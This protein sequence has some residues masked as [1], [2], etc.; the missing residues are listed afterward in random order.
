MADGLEGYCPVDM[1]QEVKKT[2]EHE[3]TALERQHLTSASAARLA[4]QEAL[5]QEQQ[6]WQ[7]DRDSV[8]QKLTMQ[9]TAAEMQVRQTASPN[10]TSYKRS[11]PLWL[12]TLTGNADVYELVIFIFT[13]Q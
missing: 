11:M 1:L 10:I 5:R 7:Q 12:Y 6:Q 8:V 2:C 4:A 9:Q 3:K 13:A